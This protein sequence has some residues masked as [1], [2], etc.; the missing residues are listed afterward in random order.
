MFARMEAAMSD[1]F[2][3]SDTNWRRYGF[4]RPGTTSYQ[5]ARASVILIDILLGCLLM[6]CGSTIHNDE[7]QYAGVAV[8][9]VPLGLGMVWLNWTAKDRL[10]D[11]QRRAEIKARLDND[12]RSLGF[13]V[14]TWVGLVALRVLAAAAAWYLV[15]HLPKSIDAGGASMA[16]ALV[17]ISLTA[18]TIACDPS[19]N[20]QINR[21]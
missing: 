9:V 1:E 12:R 18:L 13:Q 2:E 5:K 21:P 10:E 6:Q 7:V 4:F 3:S 15:R 20:S 19:K 14:L 16:F 8:M 11:A 17:V